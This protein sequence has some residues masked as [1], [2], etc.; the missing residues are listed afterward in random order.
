MNGMNIECRCIFMNCYI[1][2]YKFICKIFIKF[3]NYK[4]LEEINLFFD[5]LFFIFRLKF[6]FIY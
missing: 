5:I 1:I 3:F 2:I 6:F 4:I